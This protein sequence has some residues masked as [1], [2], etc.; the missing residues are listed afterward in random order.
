[1]LQITR[2]RL[3]WCGLLTAAIAATLGY[4]LVPAH[5]DRLLRQARAALDRGDAP[6]AGRILDRLDQRGH[7][8]HAR[9]LRGEIWLRLGRPQPPGDTNSPAPSPRDA[10]SPTAFRS[11]LRELSQV[12]DDGPLGADAAVLAAECFVRLD[13]RFFAS[14]GLHAV[15]RRFPDHKEAH[16]WLAAI[17]ID[18]HSPAQAIHHLREWGR[19]DPEQ[20]R[21]FRWIG[22][23]CRDYHRIAEALEAYREAL[24]RHLLPEDRAKVV[25]ELVEL[26]IDR[27]ADYA[28]ALELLEG[29][30]EPV[31]EGPA[32]QALRA[33]CLWCLGRT[34]EAVALLDSTLRTDANL[35]R[36]LRLRASIHLGED[37]PGDA[38]PLLEQALRLDPQDYASRQYLIEAYQ[39]LKDG[40]RVK[41]HQRLAE[42]VQRAR[43]ELTQLFEKTNTRPWDDEL[44]CE[45]AELCLKL[46]RTQ[47]ARMA[48]QAAL[49]C[50]PAN[51]QARRRLAETPSGPP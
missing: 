33:E 42:E 18:I 30:P 1:M 14:E 51:E 25:R 11:A 13:D 41:E 28:G 27:H 45:I 43:L 44:R 50:N 46:N 26:L 47:E 20:G 21:P 16:R 32:L 5:P 3:L 4:W 38:L 29:H 34:K 9:L 37:R 7:A 6:A 40:D 36:A 12:A 22:L 10:G 17:Y 19:L 15:V 2:S 8:Q 23:F 49:A 31:Q 35:V 48:L 24:R 39:R